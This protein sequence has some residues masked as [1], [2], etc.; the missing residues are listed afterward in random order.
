MRAQFL[1]HLLCPLY[2]IRIPI[3]VHQNTEWET[4]QHK[5]FIFLTY[6]VTYFLVCMLLG[7]CLL[8]FDTL[9]VT[10]AEMFPDQFMPDPF[11]CLM[12]LSP[13]FF[14][15]PLCRTV[16]H[17]ADKWHS[18]S[19]TW[20]QCWEGD[21]LSLGAVGTLSVKLTRS[22]TH[23]CSSICNTLFYATLAESENTSLALFG[24]GW[25]W[26]FDL[27]ADLKCP[28]V[29]KTQLLWVEKIM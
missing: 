22:F 24:F 2:A 21:S 28:L 10:H 3:R 26:R 4:S 29:W 19:L 6:F 20:G 27:D 9:C 18:F 13:C 25:F 11:C 15:C 12:L 1:L 8:G 16:P 14:C 17:Q 7:S 23:V 5:G